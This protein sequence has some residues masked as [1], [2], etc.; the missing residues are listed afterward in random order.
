MGWEMNQVSQSKVKNERSKMS[1]QNKV[2]WKKGKKKRYINNP[3]RIH[4]KMDEPNTH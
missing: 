4:Q 3:R 2:K 1:L